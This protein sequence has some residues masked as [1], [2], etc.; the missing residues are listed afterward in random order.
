MGVVFIAIKGADT[1]MNGRTN[2]GVWRPKE[3]MSVTKGSMSVNIRTGCSESWGMDR[4]VAVD[5]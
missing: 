3:F 1:Y 4:S 2:T 5:C